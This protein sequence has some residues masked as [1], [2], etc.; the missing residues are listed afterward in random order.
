MAHPIEEMWRQSGPKSKQDL[1]VER[2]SSDLKLI[3]R[4]APSTVQ[5]APPVMA[6][7]T[8]SEELTMALQR[9]WLKFDMA[10][11]PSDQSQNDYVPEIFV[12]CKLVPSF[13][14]FFKECSAELEY[15]LKKRPTVSPKIKINVGNRNE[16]ET[17]TLYNSKGEAHTTTVQS[18]STLT[19]LGQLDSDKTLDTNVTA[20]T[21]AA[22]KFNSRSKRKVR[23]VPRILANSKRR[24]NDLPKNLRMLYRRYKIKDCFV[25]MYK[26]PYTDNF[27]LT[28]PESY[29]V[30]TLTENQYNAERLNEESK[31]GYSNK[32]EQDSCPTD[33]KTDGNKTP[34]LEN[35]SGTTTDDFEPTLKQP[36]ERCNLR[37]PEENSNLQLP[38]EKSNIE[39]SEKEGCQALSNSIGNLKK[40][41]NLSMPELELSSPCKEVTMTRKTPPRINSQ[42]PAL[43]ITPTL[44]ETDSIRPSKNGSHS[45]TIKHTVDYL[46]NQNSKDS[47][48]SSNIDGNRSESPEK[49]LSSASIQIF[50]KS[51]DKETTL[52]RDKNSPSPKLLEQNS[53]QSTRVARRD[54]NSSPNSEVS[55]TRN[56][57]AASDTKSS[58]PKPVS[59]STSHSI[60][61]EMMQPL[62]NRFPHEEIKANQILRRHSLGEEDRIRTG[63]PS[64]NGH[65]GS[66]KR[67]R[68]KSKEDGR[69]STENC[70]VRTSGGPPFTSESNWDFQGKRTT[71][72]PEENGVVA[73]QTS[74]AKNCDKPYSERVRMTWPVPSSTGVSVVIKEEPKDDSDPTEP[75]TKKPKCDED[76]YLWWMARRVKKEYAKT[77]MELKTVTFKIYSCFRCHKEFSEHKHWSKHICVPETN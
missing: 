5:Q 12:A 66:T 34:G 65:Q 15:I 21:T 22:R 40:N 63:I 14:D 76:T 49:L 2:V 23:N 74:T 1:F 62:E 57:V 70:R 35:G 28:S 26:V 77:E 4:R 29:K 69:Q 10:R 30:T 11:K 17:I 6:P 55:L 42:S 47:P 67:V 61:K 27:S 37:Q 75:P 71:H 53:V 20:S 9:P 44:A 31:E 64:R 52:R 3:I 7:K 41:E 72:P 54:E 24:F 38:E 58:S 16:G 32:L 51:Q 36:E 73:T 59:S 45:E 39:Q 48:P 13:D 56:K 18:G 46:I 60:S 8:K 19:T 50:R 25:F 43:S 33:D 68:S